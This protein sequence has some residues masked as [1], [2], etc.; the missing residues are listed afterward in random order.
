MALAPPSFLPCL[1]QTCMATNHIPSHTRPHTGRGPDL[2][3]AQ[4]WENLTGQQ[5]DRALA[6]AAKA[7][8]GDQGLTAAGSEPGM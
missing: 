7:P 5:L 2:Q 4:V 8:G 3:T 1:H 6:A